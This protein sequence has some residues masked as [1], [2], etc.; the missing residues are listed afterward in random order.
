MKKILRTIHGIAL[1]LILVAQPSTAAQPEPANWPKVRLSLTDW[2]KFTDIVIDGSAD[3]AASDIVYQEI[4]NCLQRLARQYLPPRHVLVVNITDIDLAGV[5]EPWR[6]AQYAKVRFMRDTQPPRLTFEYEV[7]DATGT[8]IGSGQ[9]RLTNLTFRYQVAP[10]SRD[11]T[12]FEQLLLSDWAAQALP[13]TLK[14]AERK[15]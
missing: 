4:N 9:E 14:K 13:A 7:Q 6:G 15:P 12:Y 10:V 11:N 1:G 8:Q 5:V 3:K 2:Q